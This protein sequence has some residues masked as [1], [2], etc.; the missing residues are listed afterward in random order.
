LVAHSR[1][2]TP[3]PGYR[4]TVRAALLSLALFAGCGGPTPSPSAAGASPVPG[5]PQVLACI[6]VQAAECTDVVAAIVAVLPADRPQPFSMTVNLMGCVDESDACPMSLDARVAWATVDFTDGRTPI[7]YSVFPPAAAPTLNVEEQLWEDVP[8]EPES[9]PVGGFAPVPFE[10]SFCG[11]M[12]MV[13]FDGSFW[14]P[15]GE[16]RGDGQALYAEDQGTMALLAP[17]LAE[18]RG[19]DG[20]VMRLVRFAGSRYFV[21]D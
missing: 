18:Y 20:F 10:V 17:N 21:C 14:V 1:R 7:N 15:T 3:L 12:H 11:L 16:I 13:D 4:S 8:F 6:D 5:G 19:S 9:A 2:V